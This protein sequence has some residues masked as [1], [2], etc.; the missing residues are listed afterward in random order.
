MK[1]II[2]IGTRVGFEGESTV[3]VI[4][5]YQT[6]LCC[7]TPCT[8]DHES[9]C[10]EEPYVHVRQETWYAVPL[11]KLRTIFDQPNHVGRK[12]TEAELTPVL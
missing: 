3:L 11:S 1:H 4:D 8:I 9:D 7:D 12:P 2:P 6:L 10:Y 5:G